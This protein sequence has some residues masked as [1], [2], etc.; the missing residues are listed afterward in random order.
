MSFPLY[1]H[2]E[3]SMGFFLGD[4]SIRLQNNTTKKIRESKSRFFLFG[5]STHCNETMI[6]T[7][8]YKTFTIEFKPNGF[9]RI[10]GIVAHEVADNIL[11]AN[12]VIGHEVVSLYEQL[13]EARNAL[14]IV[15]L[16]DSFLINCVSRAK[17]VYVNE[18]ITRICSQ[19]MTSNSTSIAQYAY[20]ANMS[21]RNFE[22]IFKAQVGTSPKLFYR[23]LRFN[24]ALNFKI[25]N[26]AVSWTDVVYE[27]NYY[28]SMHLIKE[29]KNF[30]NSSPTVL[31]NS[32][33]DF[34]ENGCYKIHALKPADI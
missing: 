22:R 14:E 26:P 33:P 24:A 13:Q 16:S 21:M 15:S 25:K 18:G 10:F 7:G 2:A 27:F 23:L 17:Q 31:L 32:N 8:N 9:N 5:L 20:Q 29:F 1:A 34:V 19:L 11:S 28:D 12:E 30:T 4:T 3:T 6:S